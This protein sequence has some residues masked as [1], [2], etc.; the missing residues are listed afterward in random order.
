MKRPRCTHTAKGEP[1]PFKVKKILTIQS[2][3][4]KITNYMSLQARLYLEQAE[5]LL[6]SSTSRYKFIPSFM[7][8]LGT[9]YR[10]YDFPTAYLWFRLD[11]HEKVKNIYEY[12][13]SKEI[14]NYCEQLWNGI[15]EWP[16]GF[17]DK[18][19]YEKKAEVFKQNCRMRRPLKSKITAFRIY[20]DEQ[21]KLSEENKEDNKANMLELRRIVSE[22]WKKMGLE[23][24]KIYQ[25]KS[26]Y[27]NYIC[28][29]EGSSKY[30]NYRIREITIY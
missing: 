28:K 30:R 10:R 19:Y 9:K 23:Q 17:C 15:I 5:A 16:N 8:Q 11:M 1:P 12:M 24:R 26:D 29:Y 13:S 7:T 2:V 14:D 25:H 18:Y 3:V 4:K 20:F 27:L 22:K 6:L 21:I